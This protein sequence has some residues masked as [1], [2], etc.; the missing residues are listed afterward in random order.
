MEARLAKELLDIGQISC[1]GV[2]C[3]VETSP[4]ALRLHE[5]DCQLIEAECSFGC[6]FSGKRGSVKTHEEVF[7]IC[8]FKT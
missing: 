2:G 1:R 7:V 5:E 4:A 6:K 3:Q 8:I